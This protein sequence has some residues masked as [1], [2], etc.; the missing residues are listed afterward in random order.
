MQSR[1]LTIADCPDFRKVKAG[2]AVFFIR[3]ATSDGIGMVIRAVYCIA[4]VDH[5]LTD[6]ADNK[7]NHIDPDFCYRPAGAVA[8]AYIRAAVRH[9]DKTAGNFIAVDLCRVVAVDD[10]AAVEYGDK[11]A[12]DA[13]GN[14][15]SYLTGNVAFAE[16]TALHQAGYR[17]DA[18]V[19][20]D[21]VDINVFKRETLENR[22]ARYTEKRKVVFTAAAVKTGDLLAA[23]VKIAGER[24]G[25]GADRRPIAADGDVF[26]QN[27]IR[28]GVVFV[29]VVDELGKQH[30][31]F[32]GTDLVGIVFLAGTLEL[33]FF[34]NGDGDFGTDAA[35]IVCCGGDHDLALGDACHN[36][37]FI[38]GRDLLI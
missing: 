3:V 38:D 36:A 25:F 20:A 15:V 35:L 9:A 30:Q 18:A 10:A 33:S 28:G 2:V 31:F 22:I 1:A 6:A 14:F 4:G 21:V 12:G 32:L 26:G 11:A 24:G 34:L 17:G 5:R 8:A 13:V 16:R 27:I 29:S 19:R 37:V 7:A 23:T